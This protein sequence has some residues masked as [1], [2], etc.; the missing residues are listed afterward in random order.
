M[1]V[2][3]YCNE[4]ESNL[5]QDRVL[6]SGGGFPNQY[7]KRKNNKKKRVTPLFGEAMRMSKRHAAH[8]FVWV[9]RCV[10]EEC[11]PSRKVFFGGL[12]SWKEKL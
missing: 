1:Y 2:P 11:L 6:L 5:G 8:E 3:Y 9:K 7:A 12:L 4:Q 10:G